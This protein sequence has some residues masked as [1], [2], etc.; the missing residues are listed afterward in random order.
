MK[1]LC[2]SQ[3]IRKLYKLCEDARASKMASP[4]NLYSNS[5]LVVFVHVNTTRLKAEKISYRIEQV[6][7]YIKRYT[8]VFA[9]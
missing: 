2:K 3:G 5:T 1:K 6:S 8:E 4:A 7:A 9:R